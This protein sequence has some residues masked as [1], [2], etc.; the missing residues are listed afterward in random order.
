M[1]E[2]LSQLKALTDQFKEL[3]EKFSQKQES[4]NI[5]EYRKKYTYFLIS[6]IE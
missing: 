1:L 6:V 4:F 3:N 2:I 5:L